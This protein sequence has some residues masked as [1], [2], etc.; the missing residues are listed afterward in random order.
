MA[1]AAIFSK[2]KRMY[3]GQFFTHLHRIW[4]ADKYNLHKGNNAPKL[5]VPVFLEIHFVYG[6]TWAIQGSHATKIML[7]PKIQDDGGRHL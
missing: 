1:I 4:C 5:V 7:F 3:L 2:H 6:Y